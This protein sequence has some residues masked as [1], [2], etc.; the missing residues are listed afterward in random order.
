MEKEKSIKLYFILSVIV[1]MALSTLSH[2]LY[3]WTN[4]NS[5]VGFFAPTN[6]SV[7]QHL[8]MVFYPTIVYYLIMFLILA[9][10]Y[11]LNPNK[12]FLA[13]LITILLTSFVIVGIYYFF[14]YGLNI[15]SMFVDI[16]SLVIG[17]IL[18]A[19]VSY[20]I[21]TSNKKLKLPGVVSLIF[22]FAL[23]ISVTYLDTNPQKKDLFYD[24]ENHTYERVID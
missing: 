10:K 21:Y 14:N 12:W 16:S 4:Y 20:Q 17:L 5:F 23:A 8:K 15:S 2:F 22:I 24:H 6:E 9:P 7:F 11:N 1:I 19:Y 3:Q 13:P 18:S